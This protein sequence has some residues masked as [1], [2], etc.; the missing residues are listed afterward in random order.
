MVAVA[1]VLSGNVELLLLDE[2]FEG[3]APTVV[4]ALFTVFDSYAVMRPS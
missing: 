3:L 2:L 1:R 4:L